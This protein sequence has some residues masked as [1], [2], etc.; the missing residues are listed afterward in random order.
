ME[1][2]NYLKPNFMLTLILLIALFL[3]LWGN[4]NISLYGDELTIVYDVYSLLKTGQDQLGNYLPFTFEMGAGRPPGYVYFSIP[5]VAIFGPSSLGVRG[6]SIV[7]GILIIFLLYLIGKKFFSEKIGLVT[8]FLAAISPWELSLSRGGFEAHFALFLSLF[9]IFLFVAADR[10]PINYVF[11]T[12]M[13]AT[14]IHTYPTYKLTLPLIVLGLIWYRGI[15]NI[16]QSNL[17][18]HLITAVIILFIS[19]IILIDQTLYKGSENRFW[20]INALGQE[21]IKQNILQKINSER[22]LSELPVPLSNIFHNKPLEYFKLLGESYIKNFSFDF[23]FLHGD[24][25]PRHNMATI[26]EFFIIDFLFIIL[27]LIYLFKNNRRLF[28][29]ILMWL[30][31]SPIPTAFLLEPH[32]LRSSFM[33]PPLIILSALGLSSILYNQK[34]KY[35][36]II[37]LS[38]LFIQFL[39]FTDKLYFLSTNQF[40]N[41]WSY[42]A[43]SVSEKIIESKNNFDTIIVSDQIDNIEYAYPVYAKINPKIVIEQNKNR[44]KITEYNFKKFDNVYIGHLPSNQADNLIDKLGGKVLYLASIRELNEMLLNYRTALGIDGKDAY[45]YKEYNLR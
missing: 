38:L 28:K 43:K 26:G 30:I 9:G 37:C 7:S 12:L 24:R 42:A 2:R 18:K 19:F 39:Y 21:E 13:F 31:I 15:K 16:Y 17:K 1:V 5:F 35:L 25:N 23:L 22:N 10:K 33:M 11:S 4:A 27:G 44:S 32:A 14:A 6:L 8:A 36:K 34:G 41:F 20:Q 40:G 45:F 29:L 3:R